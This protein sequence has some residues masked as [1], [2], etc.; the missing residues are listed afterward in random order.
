M[1]T[2]N[3]TVSRGN[4]QSSK[5]T[6]KLD[7]MFSPAGGQGELSMNFRHVSMSGATYKALTV[8][9]FIMDSSFSEHWWLTRCRWPCIH[10][11]YETVLKEWFFE[12]FMLFPPKNVLPEVSDGIL[13]ETDSKCTSVFVCLAYPLHRI[14]MNRVRSTPIFF[15]SQKASSGVWL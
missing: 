11:C 4:W 1:K 10:C 3:V 7:V 5:S 12:W 13:L 15:K 9:T 2:Y 14:W 8:R 6:W